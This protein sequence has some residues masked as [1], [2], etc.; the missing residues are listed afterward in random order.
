MGNQYQL[1]IQN[2]QERFDS[3]NERY[4]TRA[5]NNE[6]ELIIEACKDYMDLVNQREQVPYFTSYLRM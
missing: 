2:L 1:Y 3:L 4:L 5:I 6:T